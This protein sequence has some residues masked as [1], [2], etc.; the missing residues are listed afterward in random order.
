MRMAR[1][2]ENLPASLLRPSSLLGR[3][4]KIVIFQRPTGRPL[5][6]VSAELDSKAVGVQDV[7]RPG[8]LQA[9]ALDLG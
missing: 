1:Q 9:A 6:F 3:D 5:L 7:A 2:F 8:E 4:S